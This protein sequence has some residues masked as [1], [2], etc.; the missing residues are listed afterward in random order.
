[1]GM[2]DATKIGLAIAQNSIQA[3][4]GAISLEPSAKGNTFIITL[5]AS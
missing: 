1:M 3:H 5:P 2:G 4:G